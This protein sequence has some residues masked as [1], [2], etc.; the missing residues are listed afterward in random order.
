MPSYS[1]PEQD[2]YDVPSDA[3][4]IE[5]TVRGA[6]GGDGDSGDLEGSGGDGGE[7]TGKISGD[8]LPSTLEIRAGGSG[9]NFGSGGSYG[10]ADGGEDTSPD[11]N[12]E[13]SGG[14]GGGLSAILSDGDS[15]DNAFVVGG[16]GG[17]GG[18]AVSN[19]VGSGA[20]D[21]GDGGYSSGGDG[22][23][24]GG[25][26]D[27]GGEGGSQSSGGSAGDGIDDQPDDGSQ[28]D[29]GKGGASSDP[30]DSAYEDKVAA[31]GGGGGGY[32]GGGGGGA[33]IIGNN[34]GGSGGGGGSSY[35]DSVCYDVSYNDGVESFDGSV[36]IT[37]V[38][39]EVSDLSEEYIGA[40][41]VDLDWNA[42]N[43]DEYEVERDGSVIAT[44]SDTSYTDDDIDENT[45][46]DYQVFGLVND[47]RADS[48]GTITVTTGGPP[49]TTDIEELYRGFDL[50]AGGL[51]GDF[52]SLRI[53]RDSAEDDAVEVYDDDPDTTVTDDGLLDGLDYTYTFIGVYPRSDSSGATESGSLP[54]PA[55]SGLEADSIGDDSID[56]TWTAYHNTGDTRIE[57][58][59][60]DDG[61]WSE[62]Q[63]V[64][65]DTESATIDDLL[66]GQLYGIRV[67]AETD[68]AETID[69]AYLTVEDWEDGYADGDDVDD[70]SA[71]TADSAFTITD[72]ALLG[73]LSATVDS[74]AY[75]TARSNEG[76]G[77]DEYPSA[78]STIRTAAY[79]DSDGYFDFAW[80]IPEDETDLNANCFRIRAGPASDAGDDTGNTVLRR[81]IDGS[82]TALDEGSEIPT[83]THLDL[84]VSYEDNGDDTA[85]LELVVWEYDDGDSSWSQFQTLTASDVD[86]PELIGERGVGYAHNDGGTTR[87]DA[88]RVADEPGQHTSEPDWTP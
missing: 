63:T 36:D 85:D 9:S 55:P 77:L 66:N 31:G 32:Y 45:E 20:G 35:T 87:L 78:D 4:Y 56:I 10:G 33:A 14:G 52:D 34:S 16:G 67:V 30:F 64:A 73:S 49:E 51:N 40:S 53:E 15:I 8:D 72:D 88:Y 68:D 3:E 62:D 7:V 81:T 18:A 82:S 60:D 59:E 46:Y 37:A 5:F 21:G 39:P 13:A 71:W 38:V 44:V 65:Y 86:A 57:T 58:R 27:T 12:E 76:D 54:L 79:V 42:S 43:M 41:E 1:G 69:I 75:Q 47:D 17:G 23:D 28:P 50:T 25:E 74:T 11:D 29:G 2:T 48:T 6:G 80:A 26:D 70:G 84:A 19:Y 22:E 83:E 24:G 61:S